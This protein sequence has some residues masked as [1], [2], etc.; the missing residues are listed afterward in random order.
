LARVDSSHAVEQLLDALPL[1]LLA[2]RRDV[3]PL[4]DGAA[5]AEE[6]DPAWLAQQRERMD[7]VSRAVSRLPAD[8]R[9][10]LVLRDFEGL[11]YAEVAQVLEIGDGAVKSRIHRARAEVLKQTLGWR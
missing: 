4:C 3:A 6:H 11:S 10:A 2:A 7:A 5:A 1:E 9:A 8:Q